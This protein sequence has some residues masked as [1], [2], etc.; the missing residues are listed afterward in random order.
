MWSRLARWLDALRLAIL[1]RL[2]NHSIAMILLL[3]RRFRVALGLCLFASAAALA[4][5]P[6]VFRVSPEGVE[7]A[8]RISA[9]DWM[10][11]RALARGARDAERHGDW[12]AAITGWRLAVANDP[13]FV[14]G[15]RELV[16]LETRRWNG[17]TPPNDLWGVEHADW[18]LRLTETNRVDLD[19]AVT[20][21]GSIPLDVWTLRLLESREK[22]NTVQ[23]F[24]WLKAKLRMGDDQGFRDARAARRYPAALTSELLLYDWAYAAGWQ[25]DEI[26]RAHV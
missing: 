10:Q 5:L 6:K 26:G 24:A 1:S 17:P 15:L 14:A 22:R 8:L 19:A 9:W 21:S 7:P 23:E 3:D 13:G 16:D 11:S 18:L 4:L 12:E 2:E 20:L 25:E